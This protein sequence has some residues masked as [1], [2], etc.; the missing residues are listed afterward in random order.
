MSFVLLLGEIADFVHTGNSL[1]TW[2]S[3]LTMSSIP[4]RRTHLHPHR[5]WNDSEKPPPK[6]APAT[7]LG[8]SVSCLL[9]PCRLR[10]TR[11]TPIRPRSASIQL[12]P[13][14]LL[15][16]LRGHATLLLQRRLSL[17]PLS[18]HP[19]LLLKLAI[20]ST[21]IS[22][23][24]RITIRMFSRGRIGTSLL[25]KAL[26]HLAQRMMQARICCTLRACPEP[27]HLRM[28]LW[29]ELSAYTRRARH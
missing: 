6:I 14:L 25:H 11:Y 3:T 23:V 17:C 28:S 10:P 16:T 5:R 15:R 12:K 19:T 4:M 13:A 27:T 24:Q 21:T 8:Q 26:F 29:P 2:I 9:S 22:M 7:Y 20:A 18:S 1:K